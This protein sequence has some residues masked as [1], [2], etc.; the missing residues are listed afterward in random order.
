MHNDDDDGHGVNN[1]FFFHTMRKQFEYF[2]SFCFFLFSWNMNCTGII[3]TLLVMSCRCIGCNDIKMFIQ[4]W[5]YIIYF[6]SR[7]RVHDWVNLNMLI[8]YFVTYG[9]SYYCS[10]Y[11]I[12]FPNSNP[13]D[14]NEVGVQNN[15]IPADSEPMNMQ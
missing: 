5:W 13:I 6:F 4:I 3:S 12:A 1:F 7:I 11:K 8:Y 10:S 9:H 15:Q 14:R 2:Y